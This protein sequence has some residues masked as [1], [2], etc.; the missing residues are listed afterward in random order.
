MTATLFSVALV[1]AVA[2]V[3]P[4]LGVL[5]RG[6]VDAVLGAEVVD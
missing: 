1:F 5:S 4:P 2:G 3:P 6:R